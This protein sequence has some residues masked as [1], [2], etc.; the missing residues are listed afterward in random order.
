[1]HVNVKEI[2]KNQKQKEKELTGRDK[3]RKSQ[4][5]AQEKQVRDGWT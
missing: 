4:E 2:Q 1:M 5:F 3:F